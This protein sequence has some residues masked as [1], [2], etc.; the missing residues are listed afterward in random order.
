[1]GDLLP[2]CLESI[3]TLEEAFR[4]IFRWSLGNRVSVI[5]IGGDHSLTYA[6][7]KALAEQC[8][9]RVLLVQFDAHHDCG[10]DPFALE[11]LDHSN[12]VYHLLQSDVVCGVVQ[13]GLRGLRSPSQMVWEERVKQIPAEQIAAQT[14][15]NARE[16]FGLQS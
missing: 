9:H 5:S 6:A 7:V 12:F 8:G 15:R 11:H 13:V 16:C 3:Q 1:M 2:T 4:E 14:T 10:P